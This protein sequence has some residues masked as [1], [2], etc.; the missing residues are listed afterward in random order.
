MA[1]SAV[2]TVG[3]GPTRGAGSASEQIFS[4]AGMEAWCTESA[5][6][7]QTMSLWCCT[8][9]SGSSISVSASGGGASGG[10]GNLENRFLFLHSLRSTSLC[11]KDMP[12]P[13]LEVELMDILVGH[14]ELLLQFLCRPKRLYR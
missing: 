9:P 5:P 12:L 8:F 14:E 1:A 6:T 3:G 11:L 2:S 10:T 13:T 4:I 7:W